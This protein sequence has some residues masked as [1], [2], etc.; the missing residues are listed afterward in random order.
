MVKILDTDTCIGILKGVPKVLD[1][2][3]KCNERCALPS[4]VIAELHYGAA[5][6]KSP[7]REAQR[8]NRFADAFEEIRPT[9]LMLKKFGEIKAQLE[10]KRQRIADADLLIAATAMS[11]GITLVTGNA[12]HYSRIEGIALE[13]WF[14]R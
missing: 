3:R 12:K 2:W 7:D 8:V 10:N 5:K 13:D 14:G 1:E 11:A 9:R 4:M 6:S